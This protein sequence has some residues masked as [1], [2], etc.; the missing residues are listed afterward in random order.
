VGYGTKRAGSRRDLFADSSIARQITRRPKKLR[1]YLQAIGDSLWSGFFRRGDVLFFDFTF[2]RQAVSAALQLFVAVAPLLLSLLGPALETF[3]G[4]WQQLWEKTIS[5]P[6][7]DGKAIASV[8]WF[9]TGALDSA[10]T[11]GTFTTSFWRNC[12]LLVAALRLFF[13]IRCFHC[14]KGCQP[15]ALRA[16]PGSHDRYRFSGNM[17]LLHR[18]ARSAKPAWGKKSRVLRPSLL[19][20]PV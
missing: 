3:L 2:L 14:A 10:A 9:L 19:L 13:F 20:G 1:G 18:R 12:G 5:L 16:R 15:G 17:N 4:A 11:S 7:R 6:G 8:G